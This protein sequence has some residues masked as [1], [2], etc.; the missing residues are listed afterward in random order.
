MKQIT[1]SILAVLMF[2]GNLPAQIPSSGRSERVIKKVTPKL[3]TEFESKKLKLGNNIFIRIFKEEYVLQAWVNDG[4]KYTLFKEY[5]IAY[6]SGGLGT[7]TK[8]G[9]QKSPEGFYAITPKS[10]NPASSYHLSFNI[11]YPNAYERHRGYTGSHIMVH[12]SDVSIGCYAMTDPQIEE[13]YTIVHKAFEGGQK[14]IRVHIFPFKM[15]QKNMEKHK[16][17]KNMPFWKELV[18]GYNYFESTENPPKMRVN[19]KGKY[20]AAKDITP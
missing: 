9:D 20:Y 4:K 5:P 13:I 12:G 7:K 11:G 19:N 15:T 10:L 1:I 17:D 16:G 14:E 2:F 6:Y 3:E 18:E 8:L